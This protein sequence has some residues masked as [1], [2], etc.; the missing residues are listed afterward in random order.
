M[1]LPQSKDMQVRLIGDPK[2]PVDVNVSMNGFLSLPVSPVIDY[3]PVQGVGRPMSAGIGSSSA[4]THQ[5][6]SGYS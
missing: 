2:L 4:A 6:I 1:F 5:R 3:Q